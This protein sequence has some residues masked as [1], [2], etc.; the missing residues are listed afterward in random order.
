[1]TDGN[2]FLLYSKMEAL[3]REL[4]KLIWRLNLLLLTNIIML[5]LQLIIF[6]PAIMAMLGGHGAAGAVAQQ[7]VQQGMQVAVVG[8]HDPAQHVSTV[9][10]TVVKTV[11]KAV[12]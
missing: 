11:T 7:G 6:V 10:K 12:G 2:E 5:I 8:V 4:G 3:D 1:M 9:T